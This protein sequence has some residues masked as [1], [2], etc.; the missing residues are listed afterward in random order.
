MRPVL[1]QKSLFAASVALL[2]FSMLTLVAL[3]AWISRVPQP[4]TWKAV[5]AVLCAVLGVVASF[6]V[7]RFPSREALVGG[8]AIMALSLLRVGP[9]AEWTWASVALIVVTLLLAAPL[10]H[11][12]LRLPDRA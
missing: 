11:A 2:A 7:F 4:W 1:P 12:L 6:F 8:I 5:L 3:A 9:M 10:V